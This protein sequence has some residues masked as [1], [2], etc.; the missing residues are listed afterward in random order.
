[1]LQSLRR[2]DDHLQFPAPVEP[3]G[4][5]ST[6]AHAIH[7]SL[8]PTAVALAIVQSGRCWIGCD[9]LTVLLRRGRQW[10]TI[11]ISGQP[12]ISRHAPTVTRLEELA[13]CVAPQG[14]PWSFDRAA[15]ENRADHQSVFAAY[16]A[17]APVSQI[18]I[19]PLFED[20]QT[21][22]VR[23]R[24]R[25]F[26][27]LVCES[28]SEIGAASIP[29]ARVAQ[30]VPTAC[31]AL[32]HALKFQHIF[33]RSIRLA[34]GRGWAALSRW[35]LALWILGAM[36]LVGA[37]YALNQISA[38]IHVHATGRLAPVR[39][40]SL[41]A[42]ADGQIVKLLVPSHGRVEAGQPLL[43]LW[44]QHLSEQMIL[45][46]N[47]VIEVEQGLAGVKAELH[48][49]GRAGTERTELVRLQTRATQSEIEL[50]GLRR[51]LLL[52]EEKEAQLLVIAPIAGIVT[53]N[54]LAD[55]LAQR[56]VRRGD[57]LL[58]LADDSGPWQLELNVPERQYGKLVNPA[59]P[60]ADT[61]IPIEYRL[62]AHP[63]VSFHGL[64][65]NV[66]ARAVVIPEQGACIAVQAEIDAKELPE[67]WMGADVMARLQGPQANLAEV[68]F[69]DVVDF[70][71]RSL[72][73][74]F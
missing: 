73:Y 27:A 44:D 12:H 65:R 18:R 21:D 37:V 2:V 5:F 7:A 54:N 55:R 72:W 51:Q 10:R 17:V 56:P 47:R 20:D 52:L 26:A 23:G 74:S 50:Q 57:L 15:P 22:G 70:C 29:E 24:H 34:M 42:P 13:A 8:D 31:S 60:Q 32:V 48:E 16:L 35:K 58:E 61:A 41:Y 36:C 71:Y 28:F 9:R 63:E 33:L 3:P 19:D 25:P 40:A 59:R 53:T 43:Q 45:T 11:A 46:R 66:S 4:D 38:D 1:M 64:V 6:I 49:V 39:R 30:L 62:T 67:T 68:L 69:G 14:R